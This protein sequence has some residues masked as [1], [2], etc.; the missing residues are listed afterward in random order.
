MAITKKELIELLKTHQN[1]IDKKINDIVDVKIAKIEEERKATVIQGIDNILAAT[2]NIQV[3]PGIQ[4]N[5]I[6]EIFTR[7]IIETMKK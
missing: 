3:L 5:L 6:Q 7:E 2:C 1:S 4:A